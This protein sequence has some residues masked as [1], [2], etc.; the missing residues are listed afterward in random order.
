[1]DFGAG[2]K[3]GIKTSYQIKYVL[4]P[5]GRNVKRSPIRSIT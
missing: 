2:D 5:K 3:K 4:R 1:M